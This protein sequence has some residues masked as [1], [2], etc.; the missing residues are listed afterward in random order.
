MYKLLS[1]IGAAVQG[2]PW[3]SASLLNI[4]ALDQDLAL[5]GNEIAAAHRLVHAFGHAADAYR[6]LH[7]QLCHGAHIGQAYVPGGRRCGF[8]ARPVSH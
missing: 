5:A 8:C 6:R 2:E 4:T 1:A 7:G 3:S